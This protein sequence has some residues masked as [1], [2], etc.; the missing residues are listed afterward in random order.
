MQRLSRII[1][2]FEEN[3][4]ALLLGAMTLV[5]FIQVIAR[6]VFNSGAVWA[7]EVTVMLFAWLVLFGI[8]YGLKL[9]IHLGVDA[10]INLLSSPVRRVLATLVGI[11][12]LAY[13]VLLLWG[14][15]VYWLKFYHLGLEVQDIPFPA[16]LQEFFG[17]IEDGEPLHEKLPR[18]VVYL[19]LPVGMLLFCVRAF[20]ALWSVATGRRDMLIVSHE[21]EEIVALK[22]EER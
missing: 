16:W 4:L 11:G 22:P 8:S 5:T 19:I 12:C 15:V 13:G 21:V 10:L 14:S 20:Q 6:Y 1:T 7:L 9:G 17:M 18:Y 3:V 2:G